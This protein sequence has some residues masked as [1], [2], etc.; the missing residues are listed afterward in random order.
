[1]RSKAHDLVIT[2]S[3]VQ[4]QISAEPLITGVGWVSEAIKLVALVGSDENVFFRN[5]TCLRLMQQSRFG[6]I[7]AESPIEGSNAKHPPLY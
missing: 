2:F 1:M 4:A 7:S 6:K 5:T 3:D